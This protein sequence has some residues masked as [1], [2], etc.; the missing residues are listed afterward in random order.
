MSSPMWCDEQRLRKMHSIPSCSCRHFSSVQTSSRVL[1][2]QARPSESS[3]SRRP[4]EV[5]WHEKWSTRGRIGS[6]R[7]SPRSGPSRSVG[8]CAAARISRSPTGSARSTVRMSRSRSR[9]CRPLEGQQKRPS[10]VF[11]CRLTVATPGL[12][13]ESRSRS[14]S[15]GR[16]SG[17]FLSMRRSM[18][19]SASGSCFSLASSLAIIAAAPPLASQATYSFHSSLL[20]GSDSACTASSA[21]AP[22]APSRCAR[23]EKQPRSSGSAAKIS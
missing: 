12:R 16:C 14:A 22:V 5:P 8:N 19:S 4:S 13:Y 1:T 20:K 7:A 23:G 11:C 9:R 3:M 17:A 15:V 18:C 6:L 21:A 10:S 2:V